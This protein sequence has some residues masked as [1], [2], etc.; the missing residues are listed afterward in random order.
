M[1][2]LAVEEL[3][4]ADE[5]RLELIDNGDDVESSGNNRLVKMKLTSRYKITYE[6]SGSARR[7]KRDGDCG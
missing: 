5:E 6:D 1:D 4:K 7:L 3:I 2:D